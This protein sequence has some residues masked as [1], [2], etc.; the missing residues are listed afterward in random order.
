MHFFAQIF[1]DL[2]NWAA[3]EAAINQLPVADGHVNVLL[4]PAVEEVLYVVVL[5]LVIVEV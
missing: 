2:F 1:H 3:V 5:G 4:V